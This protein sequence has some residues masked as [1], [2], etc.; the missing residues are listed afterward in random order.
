MFRGLVT[1]LLLVAIGVTIYSFVGG[2]IQCAYTFH[3]GNKIVTG[4][5]VGQVLD[6]ELLRKQAEEASEKGLNDLLGKP[7]TK[8]A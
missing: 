5:F 6:L 7:P 4:Q 8:R 3:I 2:A 1:L